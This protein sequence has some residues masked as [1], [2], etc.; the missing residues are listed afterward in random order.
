LHKLGF[1]AIPKDKPVSNYLSLGHGIKMPVI[2]ILQFYNSIAGGTVNCSPVSLEVI[3]KMLIKVVNDN[4]GTGYP[5]KSDKIR[6]AGKTGSLKNAVLFCGYFPADNPEYSCIVVIT[7]P[8]N[9]NLSSG[10]MAGG[11]LKEIAEN[12]S[13]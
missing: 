6:I 3:R 5:A 2:E 7:N 13:K 10:L 9:G 12:I 4:T 1:T 8:K 11:V